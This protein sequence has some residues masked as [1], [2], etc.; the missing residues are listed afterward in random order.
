MGEYTPACLPRQGQSFVG[1]IGH[2]VGWGKTITSTENWPVG[3]QDYVQDVAIPIVTNQVCAVGNNDEI[4]LDEIC[5][6]ADGKSPCHGDS[7]G[8]LTVEVDGQHVLAG[9]V[10]RGSSDVCGLP[11]TY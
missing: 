3:F 10:S 1:K 9:I 5:A 7:G 2:A 11:G 8:P 4:K 6:G